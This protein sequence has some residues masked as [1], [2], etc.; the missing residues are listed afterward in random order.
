M[1]C[2]LDTFLHPVYCCPGKLFPDAILALGHFCSTVLLHRCSVT[3]A[4]AAQPHGPAAILAAHLRVPFLYW[5]YCYWHTDT[6]LYWGMVQR[7]KTSQDI[8]RQIRS[9]CSSFWKQGIVAPV[10]SLNARLESWR[11]IY[12]N[13]VLG[14]LK[15]VAHQPC[16]ADAMSVKRVF[17]PDYRQ[18]KKFCPWKIPQLRV[19]FW[20]AWS[21]PVQVATA[22]FM[23]CSVVHGRSPMSLL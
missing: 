10:N 7:A 8:V 14:Q 11:I 5:I 4:I 23:Q 18:T 20:E 13:L 9:G 12:T 1:H 21:F 6:I 15:I 16:C 17:E 2:G 22:M 19:D 3:L